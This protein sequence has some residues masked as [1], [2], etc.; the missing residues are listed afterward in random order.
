MKIYLAIPYS[1]IEEQYFQ[2]ANHVAHL[3]M[4]QGHIVYSPITHNHPI[5]KAHG[6]PTGWDFWKEFDTVFIDWC[7]IVYVT[8]IYGNM[9]KSALQLIQESKGV[10]AEIEIAKELNKSVKYFNYYD[11]K[12]QI[13]TRDKL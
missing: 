10:C 12:E 1:G 3:L 7:D 6:L 13:E 8:C 2:I 9:H 5:A 4:Q 11:G